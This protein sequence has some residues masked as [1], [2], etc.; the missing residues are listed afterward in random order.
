M[1]YDLSRL[2]DLGR[3]YA[4]QRA[5]AETTRQ[6]LTPEILAAARAKVKQGEIVRASGLTR[7]RVR[8]L[9]RAAGIEPE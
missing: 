1:T 9:C 8:Q 6:L 2:T 7:E 5:A 3:T 4:E